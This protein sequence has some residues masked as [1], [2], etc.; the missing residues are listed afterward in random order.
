MNLIFQLDWPSVSVGN[1][2]LCLHLAIIK[3]LGSQSWLLSLASRKGEEEKDKDV[4]N[5]SVCVCVCAW[6]VSKHLANVE[7]GE[8]GARKR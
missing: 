3:Y 2:W 7:I 1:V 4:N 8:S 5:V 6:L